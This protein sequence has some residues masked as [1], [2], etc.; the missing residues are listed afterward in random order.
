M[1]RC[2]ENDMKSSYKDSGGDPKQLPNLPK[3][4]GGTADSMIC[5]K[6]LW[7]YPEIVFHM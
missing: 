7:Y 2:V 6:H 5:I 3:Y 1:Q 4:V